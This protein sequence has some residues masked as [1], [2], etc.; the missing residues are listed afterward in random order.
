[1]NISTGNIG[2][3]SPDDSTLKIGAYDILKK[4]NFSGFNL[5]VFHRIR[6]FIK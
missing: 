6:I 3:L 4:S 2:V 1:M 5:D